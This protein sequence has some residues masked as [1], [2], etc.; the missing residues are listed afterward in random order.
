MEVVDYLLYTPFN[1]FTL[2]SPLVKELVVTYFP[3]LQVD[4]DRKPH[5]SFV[6]FPL[7]MKSMNSGKVAMPGGLLPETGTCMQNYYGID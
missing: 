1:G 7:R 5:L 4:N 2:F 3:E 6:Q